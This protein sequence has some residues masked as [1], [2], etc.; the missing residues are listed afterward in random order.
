MSISES[1]KAYER[2]HSTHYQDEP[3]PMSKSKLIRYIKFRARSGTF[4][5]FLTNLDQHPKHGPE[6]LQE[7]NRDSDVRKL[8][9][10]TINLWPRIAKQC[11]LPLIGIGNV[12]EAPSF[13]RK[14]GKYFRDKAKQEIMYR[15][16]VHVVEGKKSRDPTQP[17]PE[18]TGASS[19]S[20]INL[21]HPTPST[22]PMQR[23]KST[24][25]SNS[26]STTSK[27]TPSTSTTT[28]SATAT[29]KS[30]PKYD[31]KIDE[32]A[33]R[34]EL[35]Q[36]MMMPSQMRLVSQFKASAA[37]KSP[38]KTSPSSVRSASPSTPSSSASSSR[39]AVKKEKHK[40]SSPAVPTVRSTS[41]SKSK[42]AT[43]KRESIIQK[44]APVT[45]KKSTSIQKKSLDISKKQSERELW[46][47]AQK[48]HVRIERPEEDPIVKTIKRKSL[49]YSI[50]DDIEPA[51]R[52][53]PSPEIR[54]P[55]V[56]IRMA[57]PQLQEPVV[58]IIQKGLTLHP[59]QLE[60]EEEDDEDEYEEDEYEEDEYEEEEEEEEEQEEQEQEEQD[61]DEDE[62]EQHSNGRNK[63]QKR[64]DYLYDQNRLQIV[65][66]M[67][68]NHA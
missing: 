44:K 28:T 61:E 15:E 45:Q 2:F 23:S 56:V 4:P 33:L 16:R 38:S 59:Q 25:T 1:C 54:H 37:T 11:K 66:I 9:D 55:V 60:D 67:I 7:M 43:T 47:L 21:D 13:E 19:E 29:Y 46:K 24:S 31:P 8:M 48:V 5:D 68:E 14:F 58:K 35:L 6:W 12:Y 63:R 34:E 18:N 36:Q 53:S 62:Q 42:L 26:P 65:Q 51:E 39:A 49:H 10:L 64:E 41:N 22:S 27:Y 3:F 20:P 17:R 50:D 57:P 52:A 32:N 30:T 40:P